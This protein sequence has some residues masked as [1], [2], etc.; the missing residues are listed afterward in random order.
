MLEKNNISKKVDNYDEL[1]EKVIQDLEETI[2]KS[3]EP[4]SSLKY[5]EQ[6]TLNDTMNLVN[7]LFYGN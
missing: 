4:S 5:L 2:K 1:S 6:K 3:Y 7:F